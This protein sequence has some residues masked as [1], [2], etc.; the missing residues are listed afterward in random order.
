MNGDDVKKLNNTINKQSVISVGLMIIIIGAVITGTVFIT[1]VRADVD[2]FG[3]EVVEIKSD[4]IPRGELD[5]RLMNIEEGQKR[6]QSSFSRVE[7]Y[8]IK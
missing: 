1:K 6:L 7:A 8:L 5:Q 3:N 4:Y 2:N